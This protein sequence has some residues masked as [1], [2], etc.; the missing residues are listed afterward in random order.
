MYFERMCCTQRDLQQFVFIN[1]Q[2]PELCWHCIGIYRILTEYSKVTVMYWMMLY[3]AMNLN[4]QKEVI[5]AARPSL[6]KQM[7]SRNYKDFCASSYVLPTK[8]L[9]AVKHTNKPFEGHQATDMQRNWSQSGTLLPTTKLW[10]CLLNSA[11]T[12][13][14]SS[15]DFMWFFNRGFKMKVFLHKHLW[16][17]GLLQGLNEHTVS[18]RTADFRNV[19]DNP[20][21]H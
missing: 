2:I 10:A 5:K 1:F 13:L 12:K 8:M 3:N 18:H 19:S 15:L 21:F 7:Q 6:S 17:T 20:L 4:T 11:T 14:Q 9:A 16:S